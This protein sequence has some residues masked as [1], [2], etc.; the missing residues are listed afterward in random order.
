[1]QPDAAEGVGS[2]KVTGVPAA[3][4][5]GGRAVSIVTW[6]ESAPGAK[7]GRQKGGSHWLSWDLMLLTLVPLLALV[8]PNILLFL[9][10]QERPVVFIGKHPHANEALA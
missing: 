5:G 7:M 1:M 6:S 3:T 10:S 4:P 8:E 2:Y 9:G